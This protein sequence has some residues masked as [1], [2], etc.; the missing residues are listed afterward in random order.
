MLLTSGS[1]GF[2]T[3]FQFSFYCK[4][5]GKEDEIPFVQAV[6]VLYQD[7][8]KE[9]VSSVTPINA[10]SSPFGKGWEGKSPQRPPDSLKVSVR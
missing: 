9:N 10:P 5:E 7:P 3:I 8:K 1:L 4:R 2:N 6:I